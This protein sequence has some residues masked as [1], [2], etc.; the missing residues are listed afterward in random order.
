MAAQVVSLIRCHDCK[1]ASLMQWFENPI[2]ADCTLFQKR[3]VADS[4]HKCKDFVQ[5]TVESPE[6]KHFDKYEA[7][8]NMF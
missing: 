2:V 1:Y 4:R 8:D 7:R 5:S 3:M 6:I